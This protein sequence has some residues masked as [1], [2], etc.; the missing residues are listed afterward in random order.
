MSTVDHPTH[1]QHPSGIECVEI[2]RHLPHALASAFE[3]VWHW[4]HKNG[5]EDLRKA[6]WWLNDWE[7]QLA[8]IRRQRAAKAVTFGRLS[9]PVTIPGATVPLPLLGAL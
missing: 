2:S 8:E 4:R 1:Y 3:Y 5:V 6:A 9:P 7:A